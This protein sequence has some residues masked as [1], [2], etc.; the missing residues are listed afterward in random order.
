M[1]EYG[2]EPLRRLGMAGTL[3][4]AVYAGACAPAE[5]G[6]T[7]WEG[8]SAM[9]APTVAA[10]TAGPSAAV[11]REPTLEEVLAATERFR[12]VEVALAEGYLRDPG[13]ICETAVHMGRPASDGVMGIHFVRPDLLGLTSGPD[14]RV[15]GTGTHTDFLRP[16]VLIYEPQADGSLD[17]VAVENLVFI[18]AWEAAGNR[19]RPTFQGHPYDRMVDDPTTEVDEAHFFQPHYDLHVWLY[20]ENPRGLFAQFN[21]AATCE[22][23]QGGAHH[24]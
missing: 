8:V 2:K 14:E 19:E 24:H 3:I 10:G 12:D 16:G 13:N 4:I 18:E 1:R 7:G 11:E 23:H 6:E 15:N 20:R 5:A 21:P 9:E 17:L 22:H